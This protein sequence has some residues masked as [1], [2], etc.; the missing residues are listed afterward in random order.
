[1]KLGDAIATREKSLSRIKEIYA[2]IEDVQR[3]F[4][5]MGDEKAS[6]ADDDAG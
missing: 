3:D 1:M 6:G 5:A 2:L 4:A